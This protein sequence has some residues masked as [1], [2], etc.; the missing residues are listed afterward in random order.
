MELFIL[1]H[2]EAEPRTTTDD[3][4][5]LTD[6]GRADVARMIKSSLEDLGEL[7]H[8]WVSPLVRA[9]QTAEI[10]GELIGDM[11]PYTTELLSPDADPQL[12]FNQLQL[13]E[14]QGLLLVS[15]QPLVSKILDTLCGTANGY[16][17]MA[18]SSLAC[19]DIDIIAADMGKL[20][21]LRHSS[22]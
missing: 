5:Q 18:T 1:R 17:D 16:H 10:A 2:G 7:T 12:L 4:R 9:Q 3:A 15:H 22:T 14:C 13:S 11:E 20:R 21:W 8:I 19:V 6:K